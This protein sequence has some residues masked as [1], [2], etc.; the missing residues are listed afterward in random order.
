[1]PGRSGMIKALHKY[2]INRDVGKKKEKKKKS[3]VIRCA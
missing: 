3:D 2:S 1:M